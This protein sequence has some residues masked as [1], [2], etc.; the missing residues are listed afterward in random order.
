MCADNLPPDLQEVANQAGGAPSDR[1]EE[2]PYLE[3]VVKEAP[4]APQDPQANDETPAMD[5]TSEMEPEYIE[6][7]QEL[8]PGPQSV[9]RFSP[10]K[11]PRR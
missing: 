5:E 2:T 6:E 1:E 9:D 7:E 3:P 10:N 11:M 8:I 4:A